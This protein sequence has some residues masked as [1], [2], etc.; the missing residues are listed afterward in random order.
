MTFRCTEIYIANT[1]IV[2]M[3]VGYVFIVNC[4]GITLDGPESAEELIKRSKKNQPVMLFVTVKGDPSK[5][6][7]EQVSVLTHTYSKW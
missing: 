5:S 7:T 2:E 1:K 4:I 6:V 3:F